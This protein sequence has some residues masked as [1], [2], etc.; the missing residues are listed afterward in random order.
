MIERP[1]TP[2]PEWDWR[3]PLRRESESGLSWLA[4]E[5][6]L[7]GWGHHLESDKVENIKEW[8]RAHCEEA[9]QQVQHSDE[10]SR[11]RKNPLS[12][13]PDNFEEFCNPYY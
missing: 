10:M 11:I 5:A 12:I 7:S 8:I 6:Y 2:T 1:K 13:W 4:M 9:E 3:T